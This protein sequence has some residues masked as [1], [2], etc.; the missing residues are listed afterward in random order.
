M[1]Q[2]FN[3]LKYFA[4]FWFF[5]K[6]LEIVFKTIEIISDIEMILL[7]TKLFSNV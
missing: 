3:L 4:V 2:L 1:R 6:K 5:F 7:R